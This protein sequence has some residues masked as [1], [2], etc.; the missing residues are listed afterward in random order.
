V[1]YLSLRQSIGYVPQDGMLFSRSISDNISFDYERDRE[2]IMEAAALAA[3]RE[4]IDL[5]PYGFGTV[6]GEKGRR[7]SG[8]QQQRVA[9][10]RALV[11]QPGILL[12]DDVFA[13]LDYQT[14]AELLENMQTFAGGSTTLI[15]SQRVAA[16]KD[17][18]NIFVLDGG[19]VVETGTHSQLVAKGGLYFKLYEQQL[20]VGDI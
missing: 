14:Q 19:K 18:D 11:K 5:K 3:V 9:I 2:E 1:D 12:L 8:G 16:V 13:A 6:L 4:D 17:A 15:V 20:V 7:L 10:A